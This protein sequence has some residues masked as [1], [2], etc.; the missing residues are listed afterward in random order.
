ML[1]T[2]TATGDGPGEAGEAASHP[3][4]LAAQ[5]RLAREGGWERIL[6]REPL[7]GH[8]LI[9]AE[10]LEAAEV[11][12]RLSEDRFRVSVHHA[13]QRDPDRI[14]AGN[15]AVLRRALR[16]AESSAMGWT[17]EDLDVV[18]AQGRSSAV[19][20]ARWSPVTRWSSPRCMSTGPRVDPI[21]PIMIHSP[22]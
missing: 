21:L 12:V 10:L 13:G 8:D 22:L 20:A 18:R 2:G 15:I 1:E 7:R 17:G 11:L 9:D 14:A 5:A 4:V 6:A 16:Y 3:M 19:A